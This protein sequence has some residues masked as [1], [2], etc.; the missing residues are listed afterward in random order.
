MILL[1]IKNN[2]LKIT[3]FKKF[4]NEKQL[5]TNNIVKNKYLITKIWFKNK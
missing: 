3:Y 5:K 2:K 4:F 1:N